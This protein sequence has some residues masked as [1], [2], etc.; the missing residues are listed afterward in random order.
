MPAMRSRILVMTNG[1]RVALLTW[2]VVSAFAVVALSSALDSDR[3]VP[4]LG[5]T[6]AALLGSLIAP[7]YFGWRGDLRKRDH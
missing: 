4:F 6:A 5:G 7:E 1:R 3:W 2:L